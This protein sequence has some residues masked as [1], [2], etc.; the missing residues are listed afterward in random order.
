[1]V[2][3][4]G[5]KEVLKELK[6]IGRNL[7]QLVTLAHLGRVT[8]IDLESVWR[9]FSE[10]CGA[11]RMLSLIHICEGDPIL[12]AVRPNGPAV[13]LHDLLGDGQAKARTTCPGGA[14]AVQT[15][16]LI[17]IYDLKTLCPDIASQWHPSLNGALTPEMVTP[18]IG[19]AHV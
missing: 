6:S 14:G 16:S 1:M 2:V 4:D 3:I 9:A 7:N 11:V 5:L 12:G 13:E 8:V 18:E 17:H 15:L 19:R 10:L